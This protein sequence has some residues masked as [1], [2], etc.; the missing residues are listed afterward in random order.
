METH[1][2][3]VEDAEA[4]LSSKKN[5]CADILKVLM[6]HPYNWRIPEREKAACRSEFYSLLLRIE[7]RKYSKKW[8]KD[9]SRKLAE[10]IR[11]ICGPSYVIV[12]PKLC[13][14]A[15]LDYLRGNQTFI[16]QGKKGEEM[17]ERE[18]KEKLDRMWLARKGYIRERLR[19]KVTKMVFDPNFEKE[20]EITIDEF[21]ESDDEDEPTTSDEEEE[22]SSSEEEENVAAPPVKK[23]RTK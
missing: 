8:T 9:D 21:I 3:L 22:S 19:Q 18:W 6:C 4:M 1:Y 7:E 17:S 13:R 2:A 20:V 15:S 12:W 14:A 11:E 16:D 10:K 5:K 23:K